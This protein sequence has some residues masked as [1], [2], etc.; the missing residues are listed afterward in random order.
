MDPSRSHTFIWVPSALHIS[1]TDAHTS[2]HTQLHAQ[3]ATHTQH[4]Q[5]QSCFFSKRLRLV[6]NTLEMWRKV[7]VGE[8]S[9]FLKL[10]GENFWVTH[11]GRNLWQSRIL[12]QWWLSLLQIHPFVKG[13]EKARQWSARKDHQSQSQN[14]KLPFMDQIWD[15]SVIND[16]FPH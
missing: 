4:H 3:L 7:K 13:R 5:C 1:Y 9:V 2:A 11:L 8:N 6:P 16:Q 10:L 14:K 15:K 12:Q